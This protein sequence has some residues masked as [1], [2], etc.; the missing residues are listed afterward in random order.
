MPSIIQQAQAV[1]VDNVTLTGVTAGN[2]LLGSFSNPTPG[3]PTISGV[4]GGGTWAQVPGVYSNDAGAGFTGDFWT[5]ASATGGSTTA[6][7]TWSA[8]TPDH[9][10][11]IELS[12]GVV[13]DTAATGGNFNNATTLLGIPCSDPGAILFEDACVSGVSTG[14]QSPWTS[15]GTPNGNPTGHY[16]P[17]AAGTYAPTITAGHNTVIAWGASFKTAAAVPT[18]DVNRPWLADVIATPPI[19]NTELRDASAWF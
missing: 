18:Y 14:F 1:A 15:D 2:T 3:S 8:G 4:S 17:G 10:W 13:L 9:N 5:V 16:A 7:V 12:S 11:L 6:T 19:A